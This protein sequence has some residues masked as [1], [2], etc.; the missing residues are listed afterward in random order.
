MRLRGDCSTAF[1]AFTC[2]QRISLFSTLLS[3]GENSDGSQLFRFTALVASGMT[4][5]A[6]RYICDMME[7]VHCALHANRMASRSY[8]RMIEFG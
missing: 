8:L 2:K 5:Q 3:D 6:F 7:A 4:A 1:T